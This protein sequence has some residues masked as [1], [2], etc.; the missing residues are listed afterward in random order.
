MNIG[1]GVSILKVD[2]EKTYTRVDGSAIG[3]YNCVS[4]QVTADVP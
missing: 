4:K 2:N 1:S 3:G